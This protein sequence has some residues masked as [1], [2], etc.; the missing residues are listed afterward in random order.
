MPRTPSGAPTAAN[1]ATATTPAFAASTIDVA[2]LRDPQQTLRDRL[3]MGL[4]IITL[5]QPENVETKNLRTLEPY[6]VHMVFNNPHK[7][8]RIAPKLYKKTQKTSSRPTSP[9]PSP[10]LP[11]LNPYLGPNTAATPIAAPTASVAPTDV[12]SGNTTTNESMMNALLIKKSVIYAFGKLKALLDCLDHK[13]SA[14]NK[15][16]CPSTFCLSTDRHYN[17]GHNNV[18]NTSKHTSK[19]DGC[20]LTNDGGSD[21]GVWDKK[22]DYRE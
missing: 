19:K 8:S 12:A 5:H 2:G 18:N 21:D 13:D 4:A 10:T 7:K 6:I 9:S 3:S 17:N 22:A 1:H 20:S 11:P 14:R 15:G 16:N